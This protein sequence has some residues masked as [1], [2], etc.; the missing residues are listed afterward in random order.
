MRVEEETLKHSLDEL[1]RAGGHNLFAYPAQSNFSG[2]QHPLQWIGQAQERGW[3]VL[4]DAA[5][6]VPTNRLDLSQCKPDFVCLSFC[7]M[8]GYPTGIGCLLARLESLAKLHRPWFSG[9]TIT[10]HCGTRTAGT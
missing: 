10:G 6:F 9:G 3:D 1:P 7:K 8:F 2:V 5:A 4:L